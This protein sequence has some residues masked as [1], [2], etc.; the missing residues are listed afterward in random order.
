MADH[1]R[2]AVRLALVAA[3][4]IVGA[5]GAPGV[6]AS[7]RG[8]TLDLSR[9]GDFVAQSN[10]VQCVGA[11]MQ[12]MFNVIEP[13]NDRTT[14]TQL[15]LQR[16]ARRLSPPRPDGSVRQ[17]A[18][19][20]GWTAGLNR[21]GAGP[22]R[23]DGTRTIQSA[24]RNAARAIRATRRPV[25]LLMWH[26]RHAW[27][28]V[29]FRATADPART[30]D[31]VVTHAIVMDPLYPHGSSVW[32]P[33]PRPREMLTVATLGRQF[34]P[35]RK[36]HRASMW[37]AGYEGLYV[38]TLPSTGAPVSRSSGDPAAPTPQASRWSIGHARLGFAL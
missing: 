36:G 26:G 19:I 16:L 5:L 32:G 17:G 29:G 14:A 20:I 15:R 7:G 3:L 6:Q 35:R 9:P 8:Y 21:L 27:V 11:S 25:G 34:V 10:F 18:S 23:L 30:D 2:R 13:R 22:Y 24:L 33:S 31:F 1:P 37:L 4:A 28:M 38:T 12:M